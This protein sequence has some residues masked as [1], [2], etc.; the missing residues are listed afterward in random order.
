[1]A[2]TNSPTS[3]HRLGARRRAREVA[4]A[5]LYRADLLEL[6]ASAALLSL[7]E[8]LSLTAES[9]P[10]EEWQEAAFRAQT[11]D[12]AHVL[13]TGVFLERETLDAAINDLAVDWR[14]D[15]LSLTD[16]NVLRIAMW[17]LS[18][19]DQPPAAVINEAVEIAKQYGGSES[20]KFVNGIL[21][22]WLE[23]LVG[24][25]NEQSAP[26]KNKDRA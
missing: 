13:V 17:E 12:Y 3:K 15:R 20:P 14:L 7:P 25:T 10:E 1:M 16:R 5:T 23:R 26:S 19:S 21:G 8:M 2:A 24:R 6:P 4:L 22:A 18:C 9:W 11:L